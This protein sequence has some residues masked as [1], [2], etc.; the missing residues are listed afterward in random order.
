MGMQNR[1]EVRAHFVY[2]EMERQ[3]GGGLVGAFHRPVR[4]DTDNVLPGERALVNT[5][6]G[7]PDVAVG[8][9]DGKIA[10]G[11]GGHTLVI[12]TLHKHNQ[13]VCRMDILDVHSLSPLKYHTETL[14][15]PPGGL[16][17]VTLV[18]PVVKG[19][20]TPFFSGWMQDRPALPPG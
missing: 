10:A 18:Y 16:T 14:K 15:R 19:M 9:F 8:I 20:S 11:H 12:N 6:R 1:V 5:A 13:L 7:D 4:V 3:L 2:G 17:Q